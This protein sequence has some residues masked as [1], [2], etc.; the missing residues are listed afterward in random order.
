LTYNLANTNSPHGGLR[1]A[2]IA[3]SANSAVYQAWFNQP[4]TL[5]PNTH[6]IFS[7]WAKASAANPG[8]AITYYIGTVDG[9]IEWWT[10]AQITSSQLTT[11][12][13]Q[14]TGSFDT[15][16]INILPFSF[17][18]RMTCTGSAARTYFLDDLSLTA[19]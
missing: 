5:L 14:S 17:N 9:A 11:S 6:Y 12:W 4:V 7:G 13:V 10:L 18:V 2:S 15:P 3:Y 19:A 1:D 16:F 8:C